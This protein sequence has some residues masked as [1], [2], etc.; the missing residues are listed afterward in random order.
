[1]HAHII[2]NILL[3]VPNSVVVPRELDKG[4]RLTIKTVLREQSQRIYLA[5]TKSCLSSRHENCLNIFE[6][7]VF[8][9]GTE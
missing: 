2:V 5:D 9:E 3:G 4:S 1:M 8:Q 6:Y 7:L